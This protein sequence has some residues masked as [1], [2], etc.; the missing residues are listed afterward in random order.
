MS[1]HEI[2]ALPEQ[3]PNIALDVRAWYFGGFKVAGHGEMPFFDKGFPNK[4]A[5]LTG[6]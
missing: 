2:P 5:K 4:S 6:Y 3:R 1:Y